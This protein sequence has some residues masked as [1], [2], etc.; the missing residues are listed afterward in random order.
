[1]DNDDLNFL[2]ISFGSSS[3]ESNS[4]D[5]ISN[6]VIAN[7]CSGEQNNED[8]IIEKL[9][10]SFEDIE[11]DQIKEIHPNRA[12]TSN[13]IICLNKMNKI[14]L[15]VFML[16]FLTRI[17]FDIFSVDYQQDVK[18]HLE[19]VLDHCL[20]YN[21]SYKC[22]ENMAKII[23]STP[24]AAVKVPSTKYKIQKFVAP[25]FKYEF[26]VQCKTCKSYVN[27]V[28]ITCCG[29]I[30]KNI[31]SDHFVTIPIEQRLL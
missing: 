14:S 7:E 10:T 3:S 31:K 1:M 8:E 29:S 30:L 11:F 23:N 12:S 9:V 6:F 22:M 21:S 18:I 2:N 20:Q 24:N 15:Y 17:H 13:G 25:V 4:C 19:R 27:N 5:T 16:Q 26:H 28:N